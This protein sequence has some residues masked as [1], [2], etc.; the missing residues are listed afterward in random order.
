MKVVA[1]K[2]LDREPPFSPVEALVICKR[3][4][5]N[6]IRVCPHNKG[7]EGRCGHLVACNYG[8][9]ALGFETAADGWRGAPRKYRRESMDKMKEAPAGALVW[10]TGGSEGAGHVGISDGK[11]RIFG[12]DLP[13]TGRLGRFPIDKVTDE[14]TLLVPAGWTFPHFGMAAGDN[15]RP[16]KLPDKADDLPH[17][18]IA[19]RLIEAAQDV[20]A[21][22][23]R[24]LTFDPTPELEKAYRDLIKQARKDIAR[25]RALLSD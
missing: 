17:E 20:I 8:Y 25:A 22:A 3:M 12:T 10:W 6:G 9:S 18:R 4:S 7:L 2:F 5:E 24:G 14:F 11:G 19:K 13:D 1:T 23:K 21:S 16:P 15:R